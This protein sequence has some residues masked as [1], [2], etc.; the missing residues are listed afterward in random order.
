MQLSIIEKT[1]YQ[2]LKLNNPSEKRKSVRKK[3]K[4]PFLIVNV[5]G[6]DPEF[7]HTFCEAGIPFFESAERAMKAYARVL[8]YQRWRR[9]HDL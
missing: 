1:I 6:F 8:A 3:H 9:A 5:P 2:R 7:G 4:V